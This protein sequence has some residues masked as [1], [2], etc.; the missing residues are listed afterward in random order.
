MVWRVQWT[1]IWEAILIF[2]KVLEYS[3]DRSIPVTVINEIK[4]S[5]GDSRHLD[6]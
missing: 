3:F 1:V 6:W 2:S 5:F 4:V